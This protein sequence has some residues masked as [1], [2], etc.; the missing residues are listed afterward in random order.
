MKFVQS[1]PLVVIVGETASGK[2]ALAIELAQRFNGEIIAADSRTLYK[3]MDIATAKPTAQE[4]VAVKHHL[5]DVSTPDKP[6]TVSDFKQLANQAIKD[7]TKRG[8]LPFLVGGTGLYIDAILYDFQFNNSAGSAV[9]GSLNNK[10]VEELQALLQE[11]GIALPENPLNKRHLIRKLETGGA[12]AAKSE[13]RPDTLLLGLQMDREM[14]K[15]RVAQRID[16]MFK[17]GVIAEAAKLKAHYSAELDPL[18]TPGY[19]ALWQLLDGAISQQEA[20]AL[21]AQADLHLAKRQRTWFKRNKSIHW[22]DN[23]DKLTQSVDLITTL[24]NT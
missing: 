3:G 14:L 4:Q 12:V 6:L 5:I 17:A 24:M 21:F 1:K 16:A 23:R 19:K 11:R 13:L 15:D 18:K 9:R 20:K 7:I 8:K 2:T 22:L 10:S